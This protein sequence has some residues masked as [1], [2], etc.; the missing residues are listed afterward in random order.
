MSQRK[1]PPSQRG[2][3]GSDPGP[4]GEAGLRQWISNF[5]DHFRELYR[6]AIA[7]GWP[8]DLVIFSVATEDRTDVVPGNFGLFTRKQ[9]RDQTA[10]RRPELAK[11]FD[12]GPFEHAFYVHAAG[13]GA[14]LKG[15]CVAIL[16]E[17]LEGSVPEFGWTPVITP[18][19]EMKPGAPIMHIGNGRVTPAP[20]PQTG[21]EG[22]QTWVENQ[23]AYFQSFYREAVRMGWPAD[24][25]VVS[26]PK[27]D[28]TRKPPTNFKPYPR[29]NRGD[30]TRL[31]PQLRGSFDKP[32]EGY[33]GG[34]FVVATKERGRL[35]GTCTV[36][37]KLPADDQEL[38]ELG[39][40]GP[41][42]P[43]GHSLN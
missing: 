14:R 23:S 12:D 20:A 27:D 3:P 31:I 41:P 11:K 16:S 39:L 38:P 13:E 5:D 6:R 22:L 26:N 33:S 9:W 1:K 8:T 36:Y 24:I 29:A 43:P 2:N 4:Q 35:R 7:A 34:F 28:N 30:L 18:Y 10:R 37:M 40:I 42:P 19:S 15:D 17:S 25:I 32:P 21:P